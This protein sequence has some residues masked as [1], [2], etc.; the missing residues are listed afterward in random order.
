MVYDVIIIGGSFAG[1]S[2]ATIL[3][4]AR[5]SVLVIDH[6]QPRNRF[7]D[8]SH[9]LFAQDGEAPYAMIAR[10]REQ[11]LAYGCVTVQEG[12]A[13]AARANGSRYDVEL[14][15][16][17]VFSA[18]KILLATG[19][20]DE[21]PD[22]PGLRERWGKTVLHCPYCHAYEIPERARIGVLDSSGKMV[23]MEKGEDPV[24]QA[25][26]Q[27]LLLK[28]W[29]RVTYFANGFPLAPD[30]EKALHDANI[31]IERAAAEA[32]NGEAPSLR[33]LSLKDGREVE[34]DALFSSFPTVMTPLA[35]QLGCICIPG[36]WGPVI[37][38]NDRQE[39]SV[40]GVYAAGD[41]ALPAHNI[42]LA[43]ADGVKAGI[44]LHHALVFGF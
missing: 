23:V 36:I 4:R 32:L 17:S 3:G 35:A 22:L 43:A 7:S 2:A 15:G 14:A 41:A 19:V 38:V 10:A 11:L 24:M 42:T 21:L 25:V 27:A 33:S 39:T 6:H 16:G 20:A 13:I 8:Y 1:L 44:A 9:G 28:G 18:Q 5:R 31:T 29:G 37:E 12:E 26:R 34:I 30:S 40:K